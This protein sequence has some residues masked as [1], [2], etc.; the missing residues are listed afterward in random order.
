MLLSGSL[1][2]LAALQRRVLY[3]GVLGVL[4]LRGGFIAASGEAPSPAV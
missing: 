4:V 2:V 3:P 1:A